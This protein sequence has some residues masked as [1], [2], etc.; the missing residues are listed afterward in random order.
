M[1]IKIY[2]TS[3][4]YSSVLRSLPLFCHLGSFRCVALTIVVQCLFIA[5][6]CRR[7]RRILVD[8]VKIPA[9]EPKF[10]LLLPPPFQSGVRTPNSECSGAHWMPNENKTL[11]TQIQS[12]RTYVSTE[13]DN[14][15]KISNRFL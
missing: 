12:C 7:K 11:R 10:I 15:D 6:L 5:Q 14:I 8:P 13:R 9:L 3:V 1:W 4:V 2:H